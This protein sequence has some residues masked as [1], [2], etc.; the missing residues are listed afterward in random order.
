[1]FVLCKDV[2][3]RLK[4]EVVRK[5][6]QREL[7]ELQAKNREEVCGRVLCGWVGAYH[8]GG[9][10]VNSAREAVHIAVNHEDGERGVCK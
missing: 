8:V 4:R 1:M 3:L 6:S 7:K 9:W 2:M 5:E 10:S